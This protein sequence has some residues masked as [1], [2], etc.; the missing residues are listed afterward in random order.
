ML[1]S[2]DEGY[3]LGQQEAYLLLKTKSPEK[4]VGYLIAAA[5]GGLSSAQRMLGIRT[6]F[7][8]MPLFRVCDNRIRSHVFAM[9]L[10]V[11]RASAPFW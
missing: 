8:R 7:S 3:P 9:Y 4:A 11:L 5:D 10:A 1:R 6:F 2:A